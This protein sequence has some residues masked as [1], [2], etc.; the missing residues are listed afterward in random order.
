MKCT[1]SSERAGTLRTA[2]GRVAEVVVVVAA[3]VVI[4]VAEMSNESK[5]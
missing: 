5:S 2:D 3:V 4:E 1:T